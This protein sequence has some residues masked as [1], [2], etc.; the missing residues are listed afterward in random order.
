MT[1]M[2]LM[3]V[4]LVQAPGSVTPLVPPSTVVFDVED[5]S[6]TGLRPQEHQ[7]LWARIEKVLAQNG[8]AVRWRPGGRESTPTTVGQTRVKIEVL[9]LGN[10]VTWSVTMPDV[11]TGTETTKNWTDTVA[12]LESLEGLTQTLFELAER[13]RRGTKE[14][15]PEGAREATAAV[16]TAPNQQASHPAVSQSQADVTRERAAVGVAPMVAW[17]LGVVGFGVATVFG[18]KAHGYCNKYCGDATVSETT[19]NSWHRAQQLEAAGLIVGGVAALTG[20]AM[21]YFDWP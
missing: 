2:L 14:P 7:A 18:I 11:D 20:T 5:L 15:G 9:R 16:I 17:G 21:W 12:S 10:V 6:T 8:I 13:L 3:A 19:H 4:A 1:L